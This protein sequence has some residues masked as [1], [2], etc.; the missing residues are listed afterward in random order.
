MNGK[1]ILVVTDVLLVG[2]AEK[3]FAKREVINRVEDIGF[4]GSV[5]PHKAIHLLRKQQVG[6]FA[7]LE[8]GQFQLV[9]IHLFDFGTQ[10]FGTRDND[11]WSHV[12]PSRF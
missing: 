1:E 8:I 12:A 6:C 5:K 7:V 11:S 4:A 2:R 10:D 3:A 9:E